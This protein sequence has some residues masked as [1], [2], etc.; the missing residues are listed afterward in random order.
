MI[1]LTK[2]EEEFFNSNH[3]GAADKAI[4]DLFLNSAS[5]DASAYLIKTLWQTHGFALCCKDTQALAV[6]QAVIW[7]AR[8]SLRQLVECG[9]SVSQGVDTFW[10]GNGLHECVE[11]LA[12]ASQHRGRPIFRHRAWGVLVDL[13]KY[14]ANLFK[15]D[16]YGMTPRQVAE[17]HGIGYLAEMLRAA[18]QDTV[19]PSTNY[20]MSGLEAIGAYH[21]EPDEFDRL[22]NLCPD[23]IL[24]GEECICR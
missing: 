21:Y 19:L 5:S 14:G 24:P 10:G 11:Q 1:P 22:G 15:R 9:F 4:R 23:V 12:N 17:F 18:E 8:E 2:K 13:L 20:P 6:S 16:K 3:G 7:G